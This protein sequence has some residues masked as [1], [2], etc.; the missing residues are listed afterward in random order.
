MKINSTFLGLMVKSG[1]G[2]AWETSKQI[3][4]LVWL[5]SMKEGV[6]RFRVAW[7]GRL[8]ER[9]LQLKEKRIVKIIRIS[10]MTTWACQ[11][12]SLERKQKNGWTF[13]HDND[14]K[15]TNMSIIK[16]FNGHAITILLWSPQ[17]PDMNPIG[18]LWSKMHGCLWL[19]KDLSSIKDDLWKE[20]HD[21]WNILRSCWHH[22]R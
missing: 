8:L 20:L 15:H 4:W 18:Y 19:C 7:V 22:I 16:W 21:K 10:C 12:W 11:I 6:S 9:W 13:Q 3:V 2:M 1:V 5:C 14:P 17:S